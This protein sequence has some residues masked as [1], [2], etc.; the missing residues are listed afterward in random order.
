MYRSAVYRYAAGTAGMADIVHVNPS[1]GIAL[2]FTI[3]GPAYVAAV[4]MHVNAVDH[5]GMMVNIHY[6]RP[7]YV[8]VVNTITGNVPPGDEYP[9]KQRKI[10]RNANAYPGLHRRPSVIIPSG[11]PGH[12]GGAPFVT[13]YPHPAVIIVIFPASVMERRPSPF[14]IGHPGVAIGR[15]DPVS[16]CGIRMKP[17]FNI[18]YP[19]I[20][21]IRIVDPAA[22]GR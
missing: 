11:S 15:H 14:I 21:V 16:S 12:P 7:G 19:Y 5:R 3:P 6:S 9:V 18:R 1:S 22:I 8:I 2:N 13:R 17:L 20:S 4:I 10:D